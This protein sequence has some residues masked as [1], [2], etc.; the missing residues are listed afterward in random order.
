MIFK[1]RHQVGRLFVC[2]SLL[3]VSF[4][5]GGLV[6]VAGL[7]VASQT[8][9]WNGGQFPAGNAIDGDSGTFSHTNTSTPNNHWELV[10]D[11]EYEVVRVEVEM[12]GDCCGGRM[13]G[14]ILRGFDE[15]GTSVFSEAL[16]DQGVGASA[17]LEIPAGV[18][19]KRVRLG[20]E[21]GG[22]NPGANTSMIHFAEVRVFVQEESIAEVTSFT[23]SSREVTSGQAVTLAW[24]VGEADEVRLYPGGAVVSAEGSLVVT[25]TESVIYEIVATNGRGTVKEAFGVVVDGVGLPLQVSEWVASNGGSLVRSDGSTPDWIELWNPNPF[26]LDVAGYGLSDDAAEPGKFVF[27]SEVVPAGGY[28][29]VDAATVPVDGCLS[30]GFGL[31]RGAGEVLILSGPDS[32]VIEAFYYPK[33]FSDVSYGR[34]WGDEFRFFVSA[35]PGKVNGGEVVEGF[36]EDTQFSVKRGFYEAAQVVEITS[37]TPEAV[38]YVTTDGSEPGPDNGAA[39]IYN[40][41]MTITGTTV[42]RAAAFREGWKPTDVDTQTYLF[43]SQVGGQSASPANFPQQW[44]PN[45]SGMQAPVAAY[46]HFGM[47]Q[48][49]LSTLPMRDAKGVD[50][51]LEEALKS[52]PS[53]SL[54]LDAEV[55]F[56][57]S[58][59]LHRNATQR[60]RAWERNVSFEVIDPVKGSAVQANCGIRMHGG[61]NRYREMLKKSFR[62]YFRS[63]YGD[64][65]LKYALFPGSE[66]DEFDRL[67]LRSGNGKAWAS[68]WRALSGSGNSLERVTYLRDQIVRDFQAAT[69]NEAIPGTFMHLYLNGHYWGIYNPVERPTEHFAAARFGGEADEYDVLKWVRGVGHQVAAGDDVAWNRLIGLVRGNVLDAGNYEEIQELLDLENFADYMVVNHFAGNSDWI[70]NNVYAMRRRLAGEPF[71]FYCWDS[72]ESFLSVGTN[73]SDRNVSDTCT[74]LHVALRGHPDYRVLFGD[75]VHRHFFNKGALTFGQTSKVLDFHANVIDRAIVGESARW[76]GLL[77]PGNPYDRNDWLPELANL[78]GNYLNQRREITLGQLKND[79]LYPLVDA[80]VFQPKHGGQVAVGTAVTL[81]ADPAGRVFYTLDGS[82][83]RLSESTMEFSE[84]DDQIGIEGGTLIKSRVLQGGEWSALNEALFHPGNREQ[85]LYLSEL[86]YHPADGGAEFLEISNRGSVRHSLRDLRITGGIQF[87]F[88]SA[89]VT[90]IEPGQRVLLVRDAGHFSMVYPAVNFLGDYEGALGNEGDWFSLEDAEGQVLWTLSYGDSAPW[91][92]GTDGEGRSLVYRGGE[93]NEAGSW[94]PSVSMDGNPGTSDRVPL[95]EG[96]NL[97]E[98]AIAEQQVMLEGEG[99]TLD[100]TSKSGADDISLTPAWSSDLEEWS[101]E[102]FTL[103][104]QDPVGDGMV[105]Q[106]WRMAGQSDAEKL[107]F[108]VT[109][110]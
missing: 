9:E 40:G 77:R 27:S 14:T 8:S 17:V 4:A 31:G 106:R 5:P 7:G 90:E 66:I 76:G 43:A 3:A 103:L 10:L 20:F 59:G 57:P 84:A 94:R 107:F 51:E 18:G 79:G 6:E 93:P 16:V 21:N 98:Y 73:V 71:C 28:L 61:W 86:M 110:E 88:R 81:S 67:I 64:S 58:H 34:I 47:N 41:A 109:L 35:T 96:D 63:E 69:G 1:S 70:D 32:G 60:G 54:V 104:S 108:R 33:Q 49:V 105:K 89:N 24:S 38:I 23:A 101:G 52:I 25:P 75:R 45:L 85:D 19:M 56:D 65:K 13:T 2:F 72:E 62:L 37:A 99:F 30:T 48:G 78:R 29:V 53:I 80:P 97:V 26:D 74:E 12:R 87:E 91:P 68:P 95:M 83:P 82:D 55:M 100:V 44:V 22:K 15:D 46:S 50:F 102:G 36:V 39:G 11:Q 92:S 42:L